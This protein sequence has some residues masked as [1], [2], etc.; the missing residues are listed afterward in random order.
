MRLEDLKT[1][2]IPKLAPIE[3]ESNAQTIPPTIN[4]RL[5]YFKGIENKERRGGGEYPVLTYYDSPNGPHQIPTIYGSKPVDDI[6]G[7]VIL[8]PK[9]ES[10]S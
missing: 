4:K 3:I 8:V 9:E 5:G 7:V 1:M 10:V 6:R 2:N